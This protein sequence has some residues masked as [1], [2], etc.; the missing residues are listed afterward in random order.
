MWLQ[1]GKSL[2]NLDYIQRIS[3][4]LNTLSMWYKDGSRITYTYE[5]SEMAEAVLRLI[6]DVLE[7]NHIAINV[8]R[9]LTS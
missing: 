3:I 6:T 1:S 4:A 9:K 7:K 2:I 8:E 5:D